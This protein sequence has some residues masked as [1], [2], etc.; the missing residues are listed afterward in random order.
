MLKKI[1]VAVGII[2][3][4][5]VALI[6]ILSFVAPTEFSFSREIVI[7]KPKSDVFGY[8]KHLKNQND[9]G[10][11]FKQDP[12][13]KQEFT[14]TDGSPGFISKW[15]SNEVGSGEQEIASI[16][17]G[18]RI[19]TQLRFTTPF[20]SRSDSFI[21]FEA[22]GENSTKVTW[23]MKSSTPRPFNMIGLFV[24][25]ESL[26]APDFEQGLANLKQI[27]ESKPAA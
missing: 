25:L 12:A 5:I 21:T 16:K 26:I 9:W 20:E 23:G 11:W 8:V 2:V 4:G 10:P 7:A 14:G 17:E 1:A 22:I 24:S 3:I 6:A 15:E 13:M 18:E 27:L 19:D